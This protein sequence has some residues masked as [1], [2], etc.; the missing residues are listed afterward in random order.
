MTAEPPRPIEQIL[1]TTEAWCCKA[2]A[3]GPGYRLHRSPVR[4][5]PVADGHRATADFQI[6]APGQSAPATGFVFGP[7]VNGWEGEI[8]VALKDQIGA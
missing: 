3:R 4:F 7:W 5:E 2:A 6:L 8:D 1:A